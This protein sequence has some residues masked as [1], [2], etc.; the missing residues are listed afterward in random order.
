VSDFL[1]GIAP[2][3]RVP[4]VLAL[5]TP[6]LA[7]QGWRIAKAHAR[8]GSKT[9]QRLVDG[10]DI[11]PALNRWAA[12]LL[13]LA[14]VVHLG[15]PLGHNDGAL[16]TIGFLAS[17]VA[18]L[19]LAH[20]ALTGRRWRAGTVGLVLGMLTAY[21][22]VVGSKREEADQV[23]LATAVIELAALALAAV[24]ALTRPWSVKRLLVR[25]LANT[26][27]VVLAVVFG[28]AMWVVFVAGHDDHGVSGT[29][30]HDGE[31]LARLQAGIVL[32]PAGPP[33]TPQQLRAAADLADRT[34]AATLK[35]RDVAVAEAD[36]YHASGPRSGLQVHF[37]NKAHARDRRIADPDAPEMLVYA[38]QGGRSV[39]LGVVFQMPDA[40]QRGPA[41]GGAT[42]R[43]HAHNVCVGL[44]PP[45]FGVVSPYGTCPYLT[46][47]LTVAEMMHVWVVDPPGGPYVEN[48]DDAWVR[49]LLT[50]PAAHR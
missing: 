15:L 18:C 32:R 35:Y 5:V 44:L 38:I 33:A 4:L 28:V 29:H 1:I 39:L 2:E 49:T 50:T 34:K 25:P 6:I 12:W 36:G 8:A 30:H 48:L 21:S 27:I 23:G 37:E 10:W 26:G 47:S 9:A 3:H 40:G 20:R 11:A 46:A 14:G 7:V 42:T 45:G 17:G 41:I 19:W 31:F 22:L 16:L 24:P 13:L 43:W